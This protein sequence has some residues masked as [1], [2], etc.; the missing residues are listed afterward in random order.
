[1]RMS[2]V[3]PEPFGPSRPK[4]SP[5][6]IR[7]LSRFTASVTPKLLVRFSMTMASA[8]PV[9]SSGQAEEDQQGALH[10]HHVAVSE[11]ADTLTEPC[12]GHRGHFV[13]HQTGGLVE[14]VCRAR[15]DDE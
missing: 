7:R 12:L 13:D 2:V 3:F 10:A 4:I 1:M 14:P 6:R 5:S 9:P 15:L 8:I 11:P